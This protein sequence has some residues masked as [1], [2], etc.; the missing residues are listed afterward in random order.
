MRLM[1]RFG[2]LLF[3]FAALVIASFLLGGAQLE[4][5]AGDALAARTAGIALALLIFGLL[6]VDIVLPV[7]AT[8][9]A[10]TAGIVFGPL[11]GG[12]LAAAGL[13]AG[14]LAGYLVTRA[15]GDLAR[16]VNAPDHARLRR[17]LD[18]VGP[19]L[20][21]VLRPVPVLAE[22]SVLA[23]GAS[24]MPLGP[25]VVALLL[26]NLAVGFGYAVAGGVML[27][28]GAGLWIMGVSMLLPTAIFL[29]WRRM[30]LRPEAASPTY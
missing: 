25:T 22:A 7:P 10:A 3:G 9:V 23:A 29:I 16:G 13:T 17:Q 18:R 19:V 21:V 14:S 24:G 11:A 12:L 27:S 1:A 5:W 26:A 28:G 20:L 2:V 4:Q 6:A 15:A 8:V 30:F